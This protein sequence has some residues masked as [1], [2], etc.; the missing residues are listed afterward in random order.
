MV[1]ALEGEIVFTMIDN[2]ITLRAGEFILVGAG[3]PHSVLANCDS[4]IMLTKIKA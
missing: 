3:V 4:K 2:P 1:T